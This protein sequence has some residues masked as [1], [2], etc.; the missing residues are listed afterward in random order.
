L[1]VSFILGVDSRAPARIIGSILSSY[2]YQSIKY[3]GSVKQYAHTLLMAIQNNKNTHNFF[4][5]TIIKLFY[6]LGPIIFSTKT[7]ERNIVDI[8]PACNNIMFGDI[9]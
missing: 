3:T 4:L 8:A 5:V 2:M 1:K 9:Q 7:E 6:Y